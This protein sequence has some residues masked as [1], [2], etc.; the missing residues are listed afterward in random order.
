MAISSVTTSVPSHPPAVSTD[1][2]QQKPPPPKNDNDDNTVQQTR[3]PLP[4]GQGTRV[5]QL[6]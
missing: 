5:D 2:T 3:A 4:P 1:T 6:A